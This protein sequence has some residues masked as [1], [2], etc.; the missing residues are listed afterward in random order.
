MNGGDG[1]NYVGTGWP[2]VAATLIGTADNGNKVFKWISAKTT[3]PDNIIFSGGGSQ[4]AD[5]KF[6]NGGYYNH[7]GLK[8]NVTTGIRAI[9]PDNGE[10]AVYTLDGRLVRT[11][12]NGSKAL[13]GLA[14]GIYVINNK[15]IVLK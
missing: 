12:A 3:A 14:K 13:S 1:K 6:V 10:T 7:D 11:A 2:G 8:A 9:T 4:T 15:K 5:L